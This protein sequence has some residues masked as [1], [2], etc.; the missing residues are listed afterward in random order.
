MEIEK[1]SRFKNLY[2]VSLVV[3]LGI[4]FYFKVENNTLNMQEEKYNLMIIILFLLIG[5]VIVGTEMAA[6]QK[7]EKY[8]SKRSIYGGI[9][10]ATVFIIFR[11]LMSIN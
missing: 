10:I 7:D 8:V 1:Y 2:L 5:T 4:Y 6:R 3:G 11:L 9:S